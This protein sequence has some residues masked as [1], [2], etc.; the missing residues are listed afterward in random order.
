[1]KPGEIITITLLVVA[2]FLM[3]NL[4]VEHMEPM[5]PLNRLILRIGLQVNFFIV[6][7]LFFQSRDNSRKISELNKEPGECGGEDDAKEPAAAI[8]QDNGKV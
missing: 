2:G 1:M 4:L 6:I 8:N 5:G 3:A 7:Y